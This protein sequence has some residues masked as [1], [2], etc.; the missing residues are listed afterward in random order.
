LDEVAKGGG[1]LEEQRI[2]PDE[3]W[4]DSRNQVNKRL[5]RAQQAKKKCRR[6]AE[7]NTNNK[8]EDGQ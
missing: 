5:A 2:L 8:V 3:P 4:D 7:H 6:K 1:I